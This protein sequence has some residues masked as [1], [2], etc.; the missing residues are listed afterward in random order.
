MR[1]GNFC[2][3]VRIFV[4]LKNIKIE[5]YTF[6]FAPYKTGIHM[7]LYSSNKIESTKFQWED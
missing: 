5:S 7:F 4:F 2:I 6:L 3:L 1:L